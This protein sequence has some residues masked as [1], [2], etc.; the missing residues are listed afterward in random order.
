MVKLVRKCSVLLVSVILLSSLSM[1]CSKPAPQQSAQTKENPVVKKDVV[2][3]VSLQ[4]GT[5]VEETQKMMDTYAKTAGIKIDFTAMPKPVIDENLQPRIA[6]NTLPDVFSISGNAFGWQLADEGYLAD[7]GSTKAWAN[8]AEGLK[9]NYASPKGKKFGIPFGLATSAI[10]YNKK[11][12]DAAGITAE[13]K[14]WEEFLVVCQKLKDKN[15]VPMTLCGDVTYGNTFW[16]W[17]FA[18]NVVS[19]DSNWSKKIKDGTFNFNS[20]EIIDIFKKSKTLVDMG[21]VQKGVPSSTAVTT[22]QL[23]ASGAVAMHFA[24]IWFAGQLITDTQDFKTG[25]F[26]PMLQ[27]KGAGTAVVMGAE[28]GIAVSEKSKNKDEAIKLFEWFFSKEGYPLYQN[29]RKSTPPFIPEFLKDMKIDMVPQVQT[30][31]PG[32]TGAKNAGQ[33]WYEFANNDIK[34]VLYKIWQDVA[35]GVLTPEKAAEELQNAYVASIP[36]K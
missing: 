29:P 4:A 9:I 34:N 2:L 35:N 19:K 32:V 1:G 3:E 18:M 22:N 31:L 5:A 28:S 8:V 16:S 12:F 11:M 20:P 27:N 25:I 13:P 24:G 10:F 21:Y 36:K 17:G 6:S 23:Y 26:I 14:D 33:M 30:I 15:F 7:V